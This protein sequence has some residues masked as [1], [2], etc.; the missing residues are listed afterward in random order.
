[1]VAANYAARRSDL[2]KSMGLGQSRDKAAPPAKR[3][4]KPKAS[5]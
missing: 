5:A 2:A 4:R 1:M 3:G